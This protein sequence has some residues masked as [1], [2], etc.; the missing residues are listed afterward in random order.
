MTRRPTVS[1]LDVALL[2]AL[3][4]FAVLGTGAFFLA[5]VTR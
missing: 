5:I 3:L 2:V 1:A 4:V